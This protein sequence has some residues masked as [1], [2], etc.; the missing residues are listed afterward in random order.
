LIRLGSAIEDICAK[1]ARLRSEEND[2]ELHLEDWS[3]EIG[4]ILSHG[5]GTETP[6][7][8]GWMS[9]DLSGT[10]YLYPWTFAD[11]VSRAQEHAAIGCVAELC[12]TT[13]PVTP[14]RPGRKVQRVGQQMG[15][16]WPYLELDRPWDWY[17]GLSEGG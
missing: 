14:A 13:W 2:V 3:M 1:L 6:F 16:L 4:T 8:A 10:G 9:V 11:L 12:R 5:L 7:G 15:H 17:W